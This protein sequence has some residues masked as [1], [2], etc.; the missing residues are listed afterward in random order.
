[1]SIQFDTA[2]LT[3]YLTN[4]YSAISSRLF[5][6]TAAV[7]AEM[8]AYAKQNA[9]WTDRTGN[10]RRTLAGFVKQ[11]GEDTLLIGLAGHMPYSPVLE[12]YYGGRYSIILPTVD[13][14]APRIMEAVVNASLRMGGMGG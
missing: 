8:E 3:G 6:G 9:P 10:A 13:S 7:A 12:L 14:Y 5:H 1:M 4:C 2:A 11:H